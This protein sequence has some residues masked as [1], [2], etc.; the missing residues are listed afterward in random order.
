[1]LVAYDLVGGR[2]LCLQAL[3]EP[4]QRPRNLRILVAEP[5]DELNSERSGQGSLFMTLKNRAKPFRRVRLHPEQPV[6]QR[7]C[8]LARGATGDDA[9]RPAS[10]IFHERDP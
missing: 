3:L 4:Y 5:L 7:I 2:A 6:G 1:V 9:S 10:K 8:F